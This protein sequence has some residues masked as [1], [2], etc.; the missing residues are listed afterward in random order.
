MPQT[1]PATES[2]SEWG[3]YHANPRQL[4]NVAKQLAELG[5]ENVTISRLLKI[6]SEILTHD[7]NQLPPLVDVLRFVETHFMDG[8][9]MTFAQLSGAKAIPASEVRDF[10]AAASGAGDSLLDVLRSIKTT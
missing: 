9:E 2:G 10:F 5:T 7:V 1:N 4:Q 8:T 3:E 6:V